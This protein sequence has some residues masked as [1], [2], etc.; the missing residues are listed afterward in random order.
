MPPDNTEV[1]V[2]PPAAVGSVE[3]SGTMASLLGDYT[4]LDWRRSS[5]GPYIHDWVVVTYALVK[6]L[7]EGQH[8]AIVT[9]YFKR[10]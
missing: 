10:T 7:R 1:I 2:P 8:L 6:K 3:A 5:V 9:N 4:E